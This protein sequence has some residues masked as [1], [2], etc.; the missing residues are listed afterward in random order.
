M[1]VIIFRWMEVY[2]EKMDGTPHHVIPYHL[3]FHAI[4]TPKIQYDVNVA[5]A[6]SIMLLT[7]HYWSGGWRYTLF[8]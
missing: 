6:V 8:V 3:I 1:T 7:T 5:N 4:K 2:P